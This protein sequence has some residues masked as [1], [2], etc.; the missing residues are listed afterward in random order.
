MLALGLLAAALGGCGRL[1]YYAQSVG[2]HLDLMGRSR[3]IP[4]LLAPGAETPP[5]LRRRLALVRDIRAFASAELG[6]PDN[7]SYRSFAALERPFA[8]WSVVAAPPLG[9][10]PRTWCFPFAGCVAYRGY[11][12]RDAARRFADR[13]ERRGDD[14][15]LAGVPAYSTLGWLDDPLPSTVVHWPPRHLAGLLFHELA[16]QVVYVDD[17][18]GFNE[19]FATTVERVGVRRWLRAAGREAA[20]A[21]VAAEEREEALLLDLLARTRERLAA[22]YGGEGSRAERLR[23][24]EAVLEDQIGRAHV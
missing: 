6:L 12:D 23:R 4:D 9:L 15:Y 18:S 10:E 13:L 20:L 14:V 24:K 11:F 1:G 2:G 8:V 5:E 17:D 7:P 22:V 21:T 16:H 19:A 3:P